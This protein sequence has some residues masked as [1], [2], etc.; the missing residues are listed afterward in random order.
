LAVLLACLSL[1]TLITTRMIIKINKDTEAHTKRV[2]GLDVVRAVA[3]LSVTYMHGSLLLPAQWQY[4]SRLPLPA[5]DGVSLFFVLSG[6]LIG[7]ILLK[8]MKGTQ[9]TAYDLLGF[10]IRRWFRTVPNYL[11]VLV[12]LL[13]CQHFVVAQPSRFNYKY[14]FFLQNFA[15]PQPNFFPESWSL[16]VEELFYFVF[17]LLCILLGYFLKRKSKVLVVAAII[18]LCLPILL[19]IHAFVIGYGLDMT[20]NARAN[21]DEYYRKVACFR[22]DSIMYGVIGAYLYEFK[23]GQWVKLRLP[24]LIASFGVIIY[25]TIYSR[26]NPNAAAFNAVYRYNLESM[27]ALLM[28]PYFSTI[29][30]IRFMRITQVVTFISAISYSMYLLN[31][32]VVMFTLLPATLKVLSLKNQSVGTCVF[33]WVIYWTYTILGSYILYR[34]FEKPVMDLRD[35]FDFKKRPSYTTPQETEAW[36]RRASVAVAD[37]SSHSYQVPLRF[38]AP[39]DLP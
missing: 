18:F 25:L 8:S 35:R 28:L 12:A 31:Y 4:Y 20:H 38:D 39:T 30:S 34:W 3:I 11:L 24:C 22:L 9:F 21:F 27:A 32:S 19:R 33:K 2:F 7:G 14:L 15:A 5:I 13:A 16:T 10:W 23:Q 36:R 26:L 29:K 17:P 1:L 6:F 37:F